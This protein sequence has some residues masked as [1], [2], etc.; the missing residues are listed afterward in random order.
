VRTGWFR[1]AQAGG[2]SR[3]QGVRRLGDLAARFLSFVGD[4]LGAHV[5]AIYIAD[6]GGSFRRF[7]AY[8]LDPGVAGPETVQEGE[9]LAG[10]VVRD[11]RLVHLKDVPEKYL[12]V[13]S[14]L[15]GHPPRELLIVPAATDDRVLALLELGFLTP[16][17]AACLELFSRVSES[18]ASAVR[19][20]HY[21][22]RQ[23]EL[24]AETQRQAEE[25][26]AQQEELKTQNEELEQQ[27]RVL[28]ASQARLENQQAELEQINA[29]LEEHTQTLEHQ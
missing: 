15:G 4:S 19:S 2:L 8:A 6:Y 26:Q 12:D 23:T 27:S 5:G 7:G 3:S 28:Q 18:I 9:G 29:Q 16:V 20:A 22:M 14:S 10:Q 21:R 17:D 25:L 1:G 13:R 11:N 24:L